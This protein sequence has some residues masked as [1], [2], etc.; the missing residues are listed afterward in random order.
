VLE[1]DQAEQPADAASEQRVR[2]SY[3]APKAGPT[4]KRSEAQ[5]GRRGPYQAPSDRRTAL[6]ESRVA[7]RADRARKAQAMQRGE[8]WALPAKDR[9]PVRALARDYVDARRGL[10]E[11]YLLA[12]IPIFILIFFPVTSVKL[13]ADILVLGVLLIVG[14]EGFY[15]GRKVQ[16]LAQQRY[17]GQ[18]TRGIKMY[19]AMRGT[20]MRRLRM[21]KPR[22]DRGDQV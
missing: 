19:A 8:E 4:P 15:V 7:E 6:K 2:A 22:V 12:V 21:P 5:A 20:Q 14:G 16:Q 13:I 1:S 3:T 17:P 11:Y 9:G 10:S 18:S